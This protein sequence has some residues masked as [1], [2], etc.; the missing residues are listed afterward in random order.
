MAV[1]CWFPTQIPQFW[2]TAVIASYFAHF[3]SSAD[4]DALPGSMADLMRDELANVS[5]QVASHASALPRLKGNSVRPSGLF[6]SPRSRPN[7]IAIG[8]FPVVQQVV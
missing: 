8:G 7:A 5:T 2:D 6:P 1:G 3:R 4:F